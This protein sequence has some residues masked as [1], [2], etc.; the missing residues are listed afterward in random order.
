MAKFLKI[1]SSDATNPEVFIGIGEVTHVKLGDPSD[2]NTTTKITVVYTGGT[3][4]VDYTGGGTT[5][6]PQKV[7]KA[8][9]AALVANPGGQVST[10]GKPLVSEQVIQDPA[11]NAA[12]DGIM[13]ITTP[14]VYVT[15]G[16]VAF[17]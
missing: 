16:T 5:G 8:F 3:C 15:Y 10:V 2:A 14:A 17:A 6:V 7:L 11:G 9:N 4:T 13:Y 12:I 1:E